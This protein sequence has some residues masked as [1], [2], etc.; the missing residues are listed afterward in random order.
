MSDDED[1]YEYYDDELLFLDEGDPDLTVS[2]P[3]LVAMGNFKLTSCLLQ[4]NLV[5]TSFPDPVIL[6]EADLFEILGTETSDS[7]WEFFDEY[8]DHDVPVRG[9]N[10]TESRVDGTAVPKE[11]GKAGSKKRKRV[12]TEEEESKCTTRESERRRRRF[13]DENSFRGV[14]WRDA[15]KGWSPPL[16]QPGTLQSFALLPDWRR[17]L[18]KQRSEEAAPQTSAT[19]HA[20]SESDR[21]DVLSETAALG[22]TTRTLEDGLTGPERTLPPVSLVQ[23]D[24]QTNDIQGG[25]T[26][27]L[28]AE[29][30]PPSRLK[31]G[32]TAE[33]V[34]Q[35]DS[36][37][38]MSHNSVPG[39]IDLPQT[40]NAAASH[41]DNTTGPQDGVSTHQGRKRKARSPAPGQEEQDRN[42]RAH[43]QEAATNRTTRGKK[44][45][46]ASDPPNRALRER[47]KA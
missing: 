14:I 3:Y 36:Q 42:K 8:F 10:T 33:E 2:C 32:F 45:A 22:T 37:T 4:D 34:E 7:E 43:A 18:Q 20:L 6:D 5:L 31:E 9:G 21:L 38:S 15:T 13:I 40:A 29:K 26:P 12:L 23:T 11:S 27:R 1:E 16:Y 44:Q 19:G 41:Q 24:N 47:R 39:P 17:M 28:K 25:R 35:G 46:I 30:R